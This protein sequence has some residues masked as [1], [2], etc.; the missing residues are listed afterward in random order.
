MVVLYALVA[1]GPVLVALGYV[2]WRRFIQ[3]ETVA[4]SLALAVA[5]G[6]AAGVFMGVAVGL[7]LIGLVIAIK[8]MTG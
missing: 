3:G 2:L 8:H 7:L 6:L 1:V 5:I 4:G